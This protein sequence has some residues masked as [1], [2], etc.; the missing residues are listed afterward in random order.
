MSTELRSLIDVLK[1]TRSKVALSEYVYVP[2]HTPC[3]APRSGGGLLF[4]VLYEGFGREVSA[5]AWPTLGNS[6]QCELRSAEN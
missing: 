5:S 3:R 6:L 1:I 2:C 4:A